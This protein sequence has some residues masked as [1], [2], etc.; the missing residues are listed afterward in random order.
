MSVTKT[1]EIEARV[2]KAEKDLEGSCKICTKD[3]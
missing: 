1:I 3:R 2:D